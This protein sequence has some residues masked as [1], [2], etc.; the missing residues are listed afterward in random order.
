MDRSRHRA[1]LRPLPSSAYLLKTAAVRARSLVWVARSRAHSDRSGIRILFYH[2]I[3]NDHDRLAVTPKRFRQQM[4][5]LAAKGFTV[6]DVGKAARML[7]AG[8]PTDRVVGLSFDD[9]YLDLVDGAMPVLAGHGFRATVFVVT[10]VVDGTS[11]FDWYS[12]Q[13]PVMSWEQIVELDG[14]SPF[15]FEAHTVAHPNLLTLDERDARREIVDCK[16]VLE[17]RLGR[18][19][20]AFSYPAGLYG[21]REERI[22]REAGYV[23]AVSCEPGLNRSAT[24]RFALR[25]NQVDPHD[26][27]IDFRAKVDGGHDHPLPLRALHRRLRYGAK[28]ATTDPVG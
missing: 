22:V 14:S 21:S 18:P 5:F 24:D 1:R 4:D 3:S 23:V 26:W 11:A 12:V 8:A 20:E 2:R 28:R 16:H 9:G 25:R 17:Q 15:R 10:G 13:P 6:V 27:L 19:V 7:E